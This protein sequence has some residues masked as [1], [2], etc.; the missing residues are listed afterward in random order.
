[1]LG[2][3]LLPLL[4]LLPTSATPAGAEMGNGELAPAAA[5]VGSTLDK[6]AGWRCTCA[7]QTLCSPLVHTPR[8][9]DKEVFAYYEDVSPQAICCRSRV[10]STLF[11][12]D[13][14]CLW[15]II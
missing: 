4:S 6:P 13:S 1:M 2:A 15:A 3:L 10:I 7:N 12:T 14:L 9:R 8:A 11:L 5:G